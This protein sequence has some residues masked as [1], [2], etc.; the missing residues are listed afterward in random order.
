[1]N[2]LREQKNLSDVWSFLSLPDRTHGYRYFGAVAKAYVALNRRLDRDSVSD[3]IAF[4]KVHKDDKTNRDVLSRTIEKLGV[5]A[6]ED[7]RHDLQ[8]YI[9]RE[10]RDPRLADWAV[11]W[12]D[13]TNKARE[14]FTRW[15]YERRPAF[16]F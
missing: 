11:R 4:V 14:I 12:R 1:M 3:I 15:D 9:L 16:L 7:L 13:V 5:D 8:S 2:L 6:P 10:W